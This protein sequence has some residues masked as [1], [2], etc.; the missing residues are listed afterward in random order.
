MVI[1]LN[2]MN[3]ACGIAVGIKLV[4]LL[5]APFKELDG[6]ILKECEREKVLILLGIRENALT[7]R[8]DLGR[9]IVGRTMIDRLK[10]TDDLLSEIRIDIDRGLTVLAADTTLCK[11]VQII[12]IRTLLL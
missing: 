4:A 3:A 9:K 5:L 12:Q 2:R 6:D 10:I 11:R 1:K 7:E 8:F